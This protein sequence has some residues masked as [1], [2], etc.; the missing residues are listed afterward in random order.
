M[1]YYIWKCSNLL[2]EQGTYS[3]F[4]FMMNAMGSVAQ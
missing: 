2:Q 1:K 3:Q 4:H